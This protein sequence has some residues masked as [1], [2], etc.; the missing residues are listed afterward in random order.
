LASE[1][2]TLDHME[3]DKS[4][5][6]QMGGHIARIEVYRNTFKNSVGISKIK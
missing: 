6:Y 3:L 4:K 1:G 2:E 5:G